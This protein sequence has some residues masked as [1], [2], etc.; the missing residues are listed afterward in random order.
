MVAVHPW[1]RRR[2]SL[3]FSGGSAGAKILDHY[4]VG[5]ALRAF[6][7]DP[8]FGPGSVVE[9]VDADRDR[10]TLYLRLVVTGPAGLRR[11]PTVCVRR[12]E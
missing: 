9:L 11:S 5:D 2:W 3:W 8:M 10:G 6:L 4:T 7:G 1:T 12:L